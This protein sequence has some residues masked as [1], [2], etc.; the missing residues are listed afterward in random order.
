M[1]E[2]TS[3]EAILREIDLDE[4]RAFVSASRAGSMRAA[5][6][7]GHSTPSTASRQIRGLEGK[8]GITLLERTA[9]GVALTGDG[10]RF[11]RWAEQAL[12]RLDS[13]LA[14]LRSGGGALRVGRTAALGATAAGA[15]FERLAGSTAGVRAT[16]TEVAGFDDAIGQLRAGAL[17]LALVELIGEPPGDV[18]ATALTEDRLALLVPA[19][20]ELAAAAGPIS[21]ERALR[22]RL[23]AQPRG[24]ATRDLVEA[25]AAELGLTP[26]VGLG[27]SSMTRV[28]D[29]VATGVGVAFVPG[30]LL[31]GDIRG[32][33]VVVALDAPAL[34]YRIGVL[35]LSARATTPRLAAAVDALRA[36]LGDQ[37]ASVTS[38]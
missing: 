38:E 11:A 37:G 18:A 9:T 36:A 35:R 3:V 31:P 27:A 12:D 34:D 26:D 23:V 32:R 16:V 33:A 24:T 19:G 8:L 30:S 29:F 4:V 28:E 22:E 21:L 25:A 10:R 13:Q 15:A 2:L 17:D 5:A 14:E 7:A 6:E 20:H 1:S